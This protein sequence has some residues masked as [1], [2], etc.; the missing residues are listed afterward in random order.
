MLVGSGATVGRRAAGVGA[1]VGGISTASDEIRG[2]G[3]GGEGVRRAG[4]AV[5]GVADGICR[6]AVGVAAAWAGRGAA[7]ARG[8][9]A[10]GATARVAVGITT[11]TSPRITASIVLSGVGWGRGGSDWALALLPQP[12]RRISARTRKSLD[13]PGK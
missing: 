11:V 3:F 1:T 12:A 2:V 9:A 7:A 13:K 6:T 10:V 8:G 5:A 4:V